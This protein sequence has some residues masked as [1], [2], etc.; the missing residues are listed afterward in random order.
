MALTKTAD[1]LIDP[2]LVL[3]WLLSAVGAPGAMIGALVPVREA[4]AL[5]PQVALARRA[6]ASAQRKYF[7]SA[8]AAIQGVAALAIAGAA[9]TLDGAIAGRALYDGAI[10]LAVALDALKN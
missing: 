5:L 4:G 1:S 2:K 8:G 3:S 10:D 7:W 9:L 6:E